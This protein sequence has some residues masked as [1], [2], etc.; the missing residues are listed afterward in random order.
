VSP[1][2]TIPRAV[3]EVADQRVGWLRSESIEAVDDVEE[4]LDVS[5]HVVDPH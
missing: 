2:R 4:V 3:G 1:F 5:V